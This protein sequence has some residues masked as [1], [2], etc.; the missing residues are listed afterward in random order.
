MPKAIVRILPNKKQIAKDDL[1]QMHLDQYYESE[2]DWFLDRNLEIIALPL[3][4]YT[5]AYEE[6]MLEEFYARQESE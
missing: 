4:E 1:A 3:K 2:D 6:K 5:K